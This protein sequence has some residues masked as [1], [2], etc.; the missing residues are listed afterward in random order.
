MNESGKRFVA[1]AGVAEEQ[2]MEK[3]EELQEVRL[4]GDAGGEN[5]GSVGRYP[6]A[7]AADRVL[8]TAAESSQGPV[9]KASS[10]GSGRRMM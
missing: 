10:A 9:Q 1:E 4:A 3:P 6:M 8:G 2:D 5:G 7:V